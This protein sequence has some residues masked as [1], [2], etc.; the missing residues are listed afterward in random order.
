MLKICENRSTLMFIVQDFVCV[1]VFQPNL[2][3]VLWI[4]AGLLGFMLHYVIPQLRKQL[5]WLCFSH[6]ILKSKEYSQFEVRKA[7][8]VMWFEKIL[9]WLQLVEK[10]VVLPMVLLSA[11]TLD[12]DTM[13]D[14][15]SDHWTGAVTLVVCG[16]K[17]FRYNRFSFLISNPTILCCS[18]RSAFSDSSKHYMVLLVTLLFFQYDPK[19]GIIVGEAMP[20][21]KPFI[22][23][24]FVMSIVFHKMYE[25][26]LKVQFVITYIAPWQITWGS[27]FHA[28]AQP[29]S[30]PH[31][32]MLFLQA[33]ISAVFS[34]P[35]NPI[36]GSAIF[37]TSYVR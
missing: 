13:K 29:F 30:V 28:F 22:L 23:H 34:T 15:K 37:I 14:L 26:Y 16:L 2:N 5:P 19:S 33:G 32:A 10:A 7:A 3:Y 24:Y 27:A 35:L 36:L 17:L 25:F 18:F 1:F 4:M 20:G 6:P 8:K 11:V 12:V 9:I 21:K 31:S